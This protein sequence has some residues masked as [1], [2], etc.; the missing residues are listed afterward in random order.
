MK[1]KVFPLN[2]GGSINGLAERIE[3][4][5]NQ[6]LAENPD[7]SISHITSIPTGSGL[8]AVLVFYEDKKNGK[9]NKGGE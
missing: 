2:T 8:S 4:D 3:K 6:L 7:I 5:G 9:K 1:L